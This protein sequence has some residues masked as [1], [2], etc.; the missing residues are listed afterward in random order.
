MLLETYLMIASH[1][2]L[3]T[4]RKLLYS[5]FEKKN[6]KPKVKSY[7]NAKISFYKN[8]KILLKR[9]FLN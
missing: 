4:A 5:Y 1:G 2:G 9:L 8:I 7:W 3:V 6:I